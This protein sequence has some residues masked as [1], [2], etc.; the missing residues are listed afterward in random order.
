M[1]VKA[2]LKRTTLLDRAIVLLLLAA[3]VASLWLVGRGPQGGRVVVEQ[4]GKVVYTAPLDEDR[5]VSLPGPLGKTV[6]AIRGGA[7]CVAE[8]PCPLKVC[9]GMGEVARAGELLAC[10]PN[11]FLIRIEGQTSLERGDYDLLSR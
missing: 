11:E 4:G 9:M 5:T 8:S 7:V 1:A 2:V 3:A 6:L 10:V